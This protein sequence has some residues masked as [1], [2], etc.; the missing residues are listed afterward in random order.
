MLVD[1]MIKDLGVKP[2]NIL[3]VIF[4]R[5]EDKEF[6]FRKMFRNVSSDG[7]AQKMSIQATAW[8]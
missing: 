2:Q 1:N 5:E 7:A 6:L 3:Q 8:L 4:Q